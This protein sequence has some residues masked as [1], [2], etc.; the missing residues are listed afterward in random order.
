MN[1]LLFLSLLTFLSLSSLLSFSPLRYNLFTVKSL[2]QMALESDVKNMALDAA[3]AYAIQSGATN[4]S[5]ELA[6]IVRMASLEKDIKKHGAALMVELH[7]DCDLDR[8]V[9]VGHM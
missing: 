7:W 3:G 9:Y 4:T 6:Q 5:A 1:S 8:D 2:I